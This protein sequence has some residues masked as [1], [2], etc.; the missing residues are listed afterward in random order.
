[1][2]AFDD[3]VDVVAQVLGCLETKQFEEAI[4][5]CGTSKQ[6]ID[7]TEIQRCRQTRIDPV[8]EAIVRHPVA[9]SG[10]T[11][12][13]AGISARASR[14]SSALSMRWV[15]RVSWSDFAAN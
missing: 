15:S 1:M 8:A 14:A 2:P 5:L 10:R 13:R 7:R 4:P 11:P 12:W 6:V 9:R 3:G